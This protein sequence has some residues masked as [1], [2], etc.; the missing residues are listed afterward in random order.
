MKVNQKSIIIGGFAILDCIFCGLVFSSNALNNTANKVATIRSIGNYVMSESLASLNYSVATDINEEVVT[1]DDL[2]IAQE[3]MMNEQSQHLTTSQT[4]DVVNNVVTSSSV[5][6]NILNN[7]KATSNTAKKVQ[8]KVSNSQTTKTTAKKQTVKK[9]PVNIAA[10]PQ[11]VAIATYAKQFNGNPYVFG[12][13]SLTKGADC[14]GF[15]QS[16]SKHF[17]ISLPR[18]AREQATV[19][20]EVP[21]SAIQP[22][23]LVF[24]SSGGNTVTHVALYIGNNKII[25]ARTPAHGIGINSIYIMKRLHIRRVYK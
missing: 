13:T 18:T 24:Y 23:D 25:H 15:T 12:G 10:N 11:G 5:T 22:G 7:N 1:Q 3:I 9:Q 19:G 16:I 4:V 8:N 14:S 20:V 21:L 2:L 6:S 17:G